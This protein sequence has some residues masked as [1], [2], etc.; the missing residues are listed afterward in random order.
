MGIGECVCVCELALRASAC[1]GA[2]RKFRLRMCKAATMTH[3]LLTH[4]RVPHS[5]RFRRGMH[6]GS[7]NFAVQ[8]DGLFSLSLFRPSPSVSV[9]F[10]LRLRSVYEWAANKTEISSRRKRGQKMLRISRGPTIVIWRHCHGINFYSYLSRK[11]VSRIR[12]CDTKIK[13]QL[14]TITFNGS[15]GCRFRFRSWNILESLPAILHWYS[16]CASG[17]RI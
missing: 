11:Q 4:A 14:N 6:A 9:R 12:N 7:T 17:K 1:I 5:V 13:I 10:L 16:S 3:T 8:I 15:F 2:N